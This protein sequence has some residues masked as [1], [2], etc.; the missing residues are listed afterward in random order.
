MFIG[1][2]ELT[3][4]KKPILAICGCVLASTLTLADGKP[5]GFALT[6]A[7]AQQMKLEVTQTPLPKALEGIAQ[8]AGITLH[9]SG[10]SGKPVNAVCVGQSAKQ[11]LECLLDKKA[12]L[13]FRYG[14]EKAMAHGNVLVEAWVLGSDTG[15]GG[16]GDVV[17]VKPPVDTGDHP[18]ARTPDG[19]DMGHLLDM[20]QAD[21]PERRAEA[22]ATLALQRQ[23][24][25]PAIRNALETA[26]TDKSAEVR[27]Q[28]VSALA[29]YGD[30][31][32]AA[33]L[34][35]AL[36][37][38]DVSVRLMVVD[39]ADGH[40]ALLEQALNDSDETVRTYASTKLEALAAR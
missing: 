8:T 16:A 14:Q 40:P 21:D 15:Q 24:S 22:I 31:D 12:N 36:Q 19:S 13:V 27:A 5:A 11:I 37:D 4:L 9:Y 20:A 6:Q 1:K 39:S 17:T 10:L 25:D 30:A 7:N 32:A 34:A 38:N 35:A 23:A 29:K 2:I 18:Q 3:V 28:A 33:G 26:L